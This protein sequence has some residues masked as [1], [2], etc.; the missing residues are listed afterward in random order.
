MACFCILPSMLLK[1]HLR[2]YQKAS[3]PP[4]I[5]LMTAAAIYQTF[6][7]LA[8]TTKTVKSNKLAA[9]ATILYLIKAC[10][11]FK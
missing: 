1:T 6:N 10:N 8:R 5:A 9:I 2:L 11:G 4:D 7:P 3:M